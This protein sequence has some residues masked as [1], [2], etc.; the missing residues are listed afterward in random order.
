M[1]CGEGRS[2]GG[3][4]CVGYWGWGGTQGSDYLL[5]ILSYCNILTLLWP[6]AF[7]VMFQP[8]GV[9]KQEEAGKQC[10]GQG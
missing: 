2:L 9:G 7:S 10:Q 5:L 3:V 1:D 8:C 4:I 6:Y